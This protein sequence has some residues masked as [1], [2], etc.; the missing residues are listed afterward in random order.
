MTRVYLG[1]GSNIDPED[2]L[3]LAIAELRKRFGAVRLSPVY[4]SA[5]VGFDGPEFLNLVAEIETVIDPAEIHRQLEDIHALAGRERGCEKYLSRRLDID[6]L[7]YGQQCIQAP[8]VRVPRKDILEYGFVLRPLADL[9]A[10]LRHPLSGRTIGE[11]WQE[12]DCD[13][14][15]LVRSELEFMSADSPESN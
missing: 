14:Y 10:D 6:M 15:P 8:P 11:H 13:G 9:A 4:R 7:L 5:A 12:F 1:L 2:N 3:R